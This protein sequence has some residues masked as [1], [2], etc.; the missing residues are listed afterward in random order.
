MGLWSKVKN[1]FVP[2]NGIEQPQKATF[3]TREDTIYAPVSGVLVSVQEVHDEVISSGLFGRAM[4][5]C[6]LVLIASMLLAMP[7][8]PQL[9]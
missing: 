4:A 2:S 5:S 3:A 1:A 6:R 8:L 9:M 7:V